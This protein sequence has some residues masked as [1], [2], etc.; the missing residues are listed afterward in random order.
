MRPESR[1]MNI[2]IYDKHCRVRLSG[3]KQKTRQVGAPSLNNHLPR[4]RQ[5]YRIRKKTG[6]PF[7]V[8]LYP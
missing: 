4:H 1:R 7:P 3:T 2:A 8:L 6:S 5:Q